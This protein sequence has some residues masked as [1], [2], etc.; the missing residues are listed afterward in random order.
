MQKSRDIRRPR[1]GDSD[2]LTR[3][4][5]SAL[6]LKSRRPNSGPGCAYKRQACQVCAPPE[7][8]SVLAESA[9]TPDKRRRGRCF[10][11][12]LLRRPEGYSKSGP[13]PGLHR[14]LRW[15]HHG[16]G[17]ASSESRKKPLEDAATEVQLESCASCAPTM[18]LC[19]PVIAACTLLAADAV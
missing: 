14:N 10:R 19:W 13:I 6:A 11:S 18:K 3:P 9:S 12:E 16:Q 5:F 17:P 15:F 8:H 4:N 1:S 2:E 7:C